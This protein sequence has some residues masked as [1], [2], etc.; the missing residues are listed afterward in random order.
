M[1]ARAAKLFA[2]SFRILITL[3][4]EHLVEHVALSHVV[5]V[6]RGR[7][8]TLD[9]TPMGL[10]HKNKIG[11]CKPLH[12]GGQ[13][14]QRASGG[15]DGK[16]SYE[17]RRESAR[18]TLVPNAYLSVERLSSKCMM[19]FGYSAFIMGHHFLIS[20]CWSAASASGVCWSRG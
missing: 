12:F 4:H 20:A 7:Q 9:A 17:G 16:G 1:H 5:T 10:H 14:L 3:E 18:A 13:N 19:P 2:E 8:A 6:I 15:V 11:T